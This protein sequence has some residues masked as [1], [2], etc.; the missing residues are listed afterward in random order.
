MENSPP[1]L[2]PNVPPDVSRRIHAAL[3]KLHARWYELPFRERNAGSIQAI[4][5][6]YDVCAREL[7]QA[8]MALTDEGRAHLIEEL[9]NWAKVN[10]WIASQR[11]LPGPPW[12]YGGPAP[13]FQFED[14]P[15]GEIVAWARKA[16]AGR[17]ILDQAEELE[18]GI[19]PVAAASTTPDGP[20][21]DELAAGVPKTAEPLVGSG[22]ARPEPVGEP[23]TAVRYPKRAAWLQQKL[24]ERKWKPYRL[25]Q[26]GGPDPASP[27]RSCAVMRCKSGL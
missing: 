16:L 6:S 2:A 9:A 21:A 15:Q 27:R 18:R 8:N 22:T 20:S 14:I 17:I 13:V 4:R 7:R 24:D 25:D 3:L 11:R 23:S 12:H 19:A 1:N 10:G 5:D 26:E